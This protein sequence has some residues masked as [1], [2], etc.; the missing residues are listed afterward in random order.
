MRYRK[1]MGTSTGFVIQFTI[2]ALSVLLLMAAKGDEKQFPG[3][4]MFERMVG[5][6]TS[7]GKLTSAISGD[8][9][10]VTESWVGKFTDGG[11]G[12]E[13]KGDRIWNGEAQTFK[14][15]Y[16]YNA[17][18]ESLEVTYTTSSLDKELNME[19]SV[20]EAEG[21]ISL[22]APMGTEGAEIQI[23]NKFVKNKLVSR[24]NLKGNDGQ[25]VLE[26]AM[27]HSQKKKEAKKGE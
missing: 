5:E 19:V 2:V 1:E 13:V 7:E 9:I 4:V 25:A 14:W 15:A 8:V 21:I 18:I 12:F 22:L 16:S 17:T 26:G 23:E 20:N 10:V 3:K 27:T 24:V 6:W 11:S